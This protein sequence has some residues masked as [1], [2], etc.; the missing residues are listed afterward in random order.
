MTKISLLSQMAAVEAAATG[1][2]IAA[3][4]SAED[5]H[6]S[7]LQAALATLRWVKAHEHEFRTLLA[8]R[9]GAKP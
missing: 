6:R 9:Q 2:P 1:A 3:R 8:Q 4:S 7:H 5:L